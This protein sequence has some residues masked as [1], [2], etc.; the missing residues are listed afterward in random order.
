MSWVLSKQCFVINNQKKRAKS[1]ILI[2]GIVQCRRLRV[3]K[4]QEVYKI[5]L[6]FKKS[7]RTYKLYILG[8]KDKCIR[9]F[10]F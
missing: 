10:I 8:R 9:P 2:G 5:L 1:F 3:I 6:I 7:C 4:G